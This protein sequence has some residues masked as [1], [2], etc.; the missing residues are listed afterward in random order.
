[1]ILKRA[2]ESR[3]GQKKARG[4]SSAVDFMGSFSH[5]ARQGGFHK[6]YL[7]GLG[8]RNNPLFYILQAKVTGNVIKR[9]TS[10]TLLTVSESSHRCVLLFTST[11]ALVTDPEGRK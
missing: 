6:H 9:Q 1:M 8:S 5:S 7:E 4:E 2:K 3:K 10:L 11:T